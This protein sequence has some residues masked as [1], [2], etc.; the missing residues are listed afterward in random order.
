MSAKEYRCLSETPHGPHDIVR[1]WPGEWRCPGK[2]ADGDT[3]DG[4]HTFNELYDHRMALTAAW[5]TSIQRWA[6][7]RF[8]EPWRSKAHHPDDSPI[9]GGYFIV[10]VE[11][12]GESVTYHY[13]LEHW[14]LF[15]TC[16]TLEHAPKYDG[17][18]PA[19]T[20][21]TMKRWAA[22]S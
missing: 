10:G 11:L 19:D 22:S 12:D 8:P 6:P 9:Y 13:A 20:V 2:P 4:Y 5:F 18:T 3:S 14:D 16:A 15:S 1:S 7:G 21:Q 17:H